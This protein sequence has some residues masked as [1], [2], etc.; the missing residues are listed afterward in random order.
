LKIIYVTVGNGAPTNNSFHS[1]EQMVK[2]SVFNTLT[3]VGGGGGA[4]L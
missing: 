4:K 2:N 3:A 1:R